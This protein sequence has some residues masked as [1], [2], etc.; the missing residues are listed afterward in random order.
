ML[1][2]IVV[3][4]KFIGF[5]VI[6]TGLEKSRQRLTNVQA[7]NIQ[8]SHPSNE[9]N[10]ICRVSRKIRNNIWK[11]LSTV[12]AYIIFNDDDDEFSL[13]NKC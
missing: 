11:S 4:R 2:C 3:G 10:T 9:V 7:S 13:K 1:P 8:L 6:K 12:S 5:A